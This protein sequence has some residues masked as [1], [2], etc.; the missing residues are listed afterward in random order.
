LAAAC[1]LP[2]SLIGC[3]REKFREVN[4]FLLKKFMAGRKT[5][6][7]G[8]FMVLTVFGDGKSW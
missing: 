6:F 2:A 8:D 3:P 7:A 5:L 4:F 1:G